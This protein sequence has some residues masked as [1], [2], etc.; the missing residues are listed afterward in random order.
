M[1]SNLIE[2][3][4]KNYLL[5]LV[6][7][8]FFIR[9]YTRFAGGGGGPELQEY[10]GHRVESITSQKQWEDTLAEA[11]AKGQLVVVDFYA[12]WCGPCRVAAPK[13]GQMST[14]KEGD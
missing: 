13:F 11:N 9:L 4:Q 12:T 14:R 7:T 8:Y 10:P 5:V 1:L 3:V 6:A 2:F